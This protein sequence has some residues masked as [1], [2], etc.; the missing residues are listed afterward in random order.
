MQES[1]SGKGLK[2]S[3]ITLLI[4]GLTLGI[5]CQVVSSNMG[6]TRLEFVLMFLSFLGTFMLFSGLF[7]FWRGRQYT[8]K[9]NV[10]RIVTDSNPDVLYLRDFRS[11]FSTAWYLFWFFT[12]GW[13]L[14]TEEEQLA[15]ALRPFGDLIAIGHPGEHLPIPGAARI[16]ASEGEW[17]ELVK[18]Q[19]QAARLV[20]IK[21][22]I[23]QNLFWELTQAVEIVESQ[24]L[25]ILVLSMKAKEY[26]SFRSKVTHALS[27][28]LPP[29]TQLKCR[30]GRVHGLIDCGV[31]WQPSVLP[32]RI[33]FSQQS[34]FAP[35]QSYFRFALRPVFERFGL[36]LQPPPNRFWLNMTLQVVSLVF[37]IL[38]FY[39]L[40]R[41]AFR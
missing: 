41:G 17:R 27:L 22:G 29:G 20:I 33:P 16:Y 24:K 5:P 7:L 11:D 14:A 25:L 37:L 30:L 23:G 6:S 8:A 1:R 34:V 15:D 12:R 10:E 26:E 39:F 3:G 21:A 13:G 9:A 36:E 4:A 40:I 28:S 2:K 18:Q 31:D 38:L 35:F 32:F 19:M